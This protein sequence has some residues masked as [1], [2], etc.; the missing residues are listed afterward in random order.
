V[1]DPEPND[2]G[3]TPHLQPVSLTTD[4]RAFGWGEVVIMLPDRWRHGCMDAQGATIPTTG[5]TAALAACKL[6]DAIPR[7]VSVGNT[8]RRSSMRG[9]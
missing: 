3:N 8:S 1:A 4:D 5:G 2:H 6:V 7:A 9:T